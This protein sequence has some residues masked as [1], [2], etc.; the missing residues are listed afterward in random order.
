MHWMWGILCLIATV[1][2]YARASYRF[3]ARIV[4]TCGMERCNEAEMCKATN[5]KHTHS[6][7]SVNSLFFSLPFCN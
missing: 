7:R 5:S 3:H 4:Q 1:M 2:P 6:H